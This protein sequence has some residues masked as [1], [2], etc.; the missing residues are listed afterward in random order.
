MA[1]KPPKPP[2]GPKM[3]I[4]W[5]EW[6]AL[7][8]LGVAR[9][10]AKVDTGARSSAIHAWDITEFSR[11]GSRW[12]RFDVHPMQRADRPSVTCEAPVVDRRGVTSSS[13][14]AEDRYVIETDLDFAHVRWPV[15]IT[16]AKRDEMGFRM[17]LG[18]TALRGRA[19][20]D[21]GRSFLAGLP[22]S[23]SM[24]AARKR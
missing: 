18:R 13:G 19:I 21:P 10:K 24:V 5:R 6:V 12:V 11:G 20:V 22:G 16:L 1:K 15:E 17:L 2:K 4:G 8:A 23:V 3:I 9:I 7:P 14:R